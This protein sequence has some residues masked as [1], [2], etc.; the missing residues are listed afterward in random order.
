MTAISAIISKDW[1][2]VASDSLL[3]E[4]SGNSVKHIEFKKSKIV[5]IQKFKASAAYWG[6]AKVGNW[7]TYDFLKIMACDAEKFLSFESFAN[8]VYN[9]LNTKLASINVNNPTDKGIGIHLAGFE[10]FEG[11]KLPELFLI[12]NYSNTSYNEIKPLD[13]SRNLYGTIKD[14]FKNGENTL[15]EKRRKVREHLSNGHV[16]IFNNGD[17]QLFNPSAKAIT[18]IFIN[19]ANRNVL[20]DKH[21]NAYLKLASNPIKII[22]MAQQDLF[23]KEHIRI[24][25]QIHDLLIT[26]EGLMI[27]NTGDN[28]I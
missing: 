25:G 7:R 13:I 28:K 16:F 15:D 10:E 19:A 9:E 12:S 20:K 1:I 11:E 18:E 22:K 24:G 23:K 6:L 8:H 27:S 21:L 5:P 4:I 26:K 14:E 17:P 3:T 2:S